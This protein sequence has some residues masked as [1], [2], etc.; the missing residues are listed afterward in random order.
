MKYWQSEI[1]EY[2]T[3]CNAEYNVD[4]N[5]DYNT[6]RP[7]EEA[8]RRTRTTSLA[9]SIQSTH[10][11][12]SDNGHSN[13][14]R[15]NSNSNNVSNTKKTKAE[16]KHEKEERRIQRNKKKE[17]MKHILAQYA[18]H[19]ISRN[20]LSDPQMKC[21]AG[22]VVGHKDLLEN[23]LNRTTTVLANEPSEVLVLPSK[24]YL[25]VWLLLL[26]VHQV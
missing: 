3:D 15:S 24:W 5:T 20:T 19:P 13:R 2:N 14:R 25:R 22:D 4:Y 26:F 17:H 18:S 6:G 8:T 23:K 9:E 21:F 11:D 1:I 7:E 16:L 12:A 10:S